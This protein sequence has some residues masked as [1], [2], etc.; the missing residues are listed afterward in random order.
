MEESLRSTFE[1]R[2]IKRSLIAAHTF[3]GD[4]DIINMKHSLKSEEN[5]EQEDVIEK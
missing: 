5:P 4:H 2:R 3:L 1:E